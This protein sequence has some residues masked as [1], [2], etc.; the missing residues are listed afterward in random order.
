M[1]AEFEKHIRESK[2]C[3]TAIKGD[4][5][6]G[7]RMLVF[8]LMIL[9]SPAMAQAPLKV[10]VDQDARGPCTTDIQSLLMFVKSP[11]VDVLGIT[12]VSGDLWLEQEVRHTLRAL[13]IAGRPEVPVYR[14]AVFP[15]VH[16]REE[17]LRWE[18]QHGDQ[19]YMGAW[20]SDR[21]PYETVALAEG[22]PQIE[23][24][25]GHAANFIVEMVD[26]HPGEIH[27]W[28]GGP[29][30]NI[31][32]ALALDPTLPEKVKA[33]TVM[34][35]GIEDARHRREFNW[36][37]DPEAARVVL[38][39]PWKELHVTPVDISVKTRHSDELVARVAE[40]DT[41]LARYIE[42]FR[43]ISPP[44]ADP[45]WTP[46]VYMW[47]EVSAAS[48]IDPSIIT[49]AR[50]LFVDVEIDH[51]AHYGFTLAWEQGQRPASG[52]RPAR[53]QFDLDLERFYD[54]YAELMT[55]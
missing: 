28:S 26:R 9:C 51:G 11:S 50:E 53:V 31:A 2:C 24:A 55:R 22:E 48:V 25:E 18:S 43:A 1:K 30:T 46:A 47:D 4:T 36:W 19:P 41:A 15:L 29:L 52:V 21:G 49:S 39:A 37:W 16:R 3:L 5:L 23:A 32:L 33:L 8:P 54:L 14:G 17:A 40:A 45:G 13:E 12:V 27:L 34:G 7:M 44:D 10:I 42:E 20:G 38:R 35:G 6:H